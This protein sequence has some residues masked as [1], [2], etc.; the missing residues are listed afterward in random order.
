M[1]A[2][3][4]RQLRLLLW[5]NW[6]FTLRSWKATALQLL[7]PCLFILLVTILS[8]LPI[9]YHD[10]L[11]PAPKTIGVL[12]K[13]TSWNKQP[14]VSLVVLQIGLLDTSI[15]C[16]NETLN[17][18]A[19]AT[20]LGRD[21]IIT[22]LGEND[23]INIEE[24]KKFQNQSNTTQAA[25]LFLQC[26]LS[27]P[28]LNYVIFYN[29]SRALR[30]QQIAFGS[31]NKPDG[32]VEIQ[33]I[34][35][36]TFIGLVSKKE[37]TFNI[38]AADFPIIYQQPSK[39]SKQ[40]S[41]SIIFMFAAISFQFIMMMYNVVSEKDLKLRQGLKL[42]GLKDSVYWLSW[43]ITGLII[44]LISTLVLMAS[45]YA[46][47]LSFF[48]NTNF[49]INFLLFFI[50]SGSMVPLAFFASVFI[51]SVSLAVS[52]AML[53]FVIGLL[54]MTLLS[55]SFLL[56][57]LFATASVRGL[58]VVLSFLPPFHLAKAIADIGIAGS[59]TDANGLPQ[60]PH[61]YGWAE[62]V[63]TRK[64][65]IFTFSPNSSDDN[66][67][68]NYET[69]DM[70]PTYYA[71]VYM[72]LDALLYGVLAWY[73][74]AVLRGNHG[75]P[76]K[77]YFF[78]L[79]SYWLGGN[80]ATSSP[81]VP[82]LMGSAAKGADNDDD[83]MLVLNAPKEAERIGEDALVVDRLTKFFTTGFLR[84]KKV[85][86]VNQLSLKVKKNEMLALLGHN[87]AGKSTTINMLTGLLEPDEGNALFYGLS[88]MNDLDT[89]KS[90]LGVCP[91]H[92]VLWEELTAREHM[93][94]FAQLKDIAPQQMEDEMNR[95]LDAVQLSHVA[96]YR[97]STFSGGMKR[98]L[99][100]ALSFLGD[101]KIMFLDEPTTGMD[102]QVRR[103]IWNLILKM[104]PGRVTI[105][106]THAMDEADI[107]GDVIAIMANG[108]L[109]VMGTSVSLK[110]NYAGYNIE[111]IVK[112]PFLNDVK[113]LV[114]QMLPNAV[115][116]STMLD[117]E[118]GNLLS[119]NLPPNQ[120]AMIVPFF[121]HLES[122]R[123][124]SEK[125]HDY[126]IS[127][128]TLEEVFMNVTL[129]HYHP[130]MTAASNTLEVHN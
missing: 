49:L 13:C 127:Q 67:M 45:G 11:S 99:S 66:A 86:A 53:I 33:S 128:T 41:A 40:A 83:D 82:A 108:S 5:K 23:T 84:K 87:G 92:D 39:E 28:N 90:M 19:K 94:L 25:I 110:N 65:I 81:C 43:A 118:G 27:P 44:A 105:M 79:P 103:E 77:F 17:G 115:L 107:L 71:F 109:K 57:Q 58:V 116:K 10:D 95:L 102:P 64:A 32:R 125:L 52:I 68:T 123:E 124:V 9:S 89:I 15:S 126:F 60:T 75:I 80:K 56:T 46:C 55:N 30:F 54:V 50:Y 76:R 6:L 119:Y 85:A 69:F 20:G 114:K 12:P 51:K 21:D 130:T 36:S 35:D 106:T 100:V 88:I 2:G 42:I 59:D 96:D 1:A 91:Q 98:R 113:D 63:T 112:E 3:K 31:P 73:L 22:H 120:S 129:E 16:A 101:P 8:L 26:T 122:D 4:F 117:V 61:H 48:W 47:Q 121:K 72:V 70:P 7:A 104:K 97:V 18:F 78:L 93:L 62:F 14:C 37:I 24:L 34:I 29:S 111:L 38:S 74:D